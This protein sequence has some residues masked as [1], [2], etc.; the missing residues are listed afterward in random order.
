MLDKITNLFFLTPAAGKRLIAKAVC[1][2]PEVI[3]ALPDHTIVVLGGSTNYYVAEELLAQI[4]QEGIFKRRH[5]YRGVTVPPKGEKPSSIPFPGDVVIKRSVASQGST[6]FD[7]APKLTKGDVII[8]GANAVD[9]QGMAGI[10]IAN[11]KIGTSAPILEATIGRRVSLILPVGL[12]KR[13][14]HGIGNIATKLNA[15]SSTGLRML[16]VTGTIVTELD[17]I[18]SLSGAEAELVAAG[19]VGGAEGGYWISVTGTQ[20]QVACASSII[21]PLME[22]IPFSLF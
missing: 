21:K 17:A 10:L 15:A 16:P 19:G 2:L 13:V 14:N 11:E 9:L 12:E 5:F 20:E 6:I 7:V 3:Q 22:E 1:Q 8:K 18:A 4:G